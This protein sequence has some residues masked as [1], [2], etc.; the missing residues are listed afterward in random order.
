MRYPVRIVVRISEDAKE[1]LDEMAEAK[2][3]KPGTV[4]RRAIMKDVYIYKAKKNP[5]DEKAH[6]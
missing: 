2:R 1:T 5:K 3:T 6:E 4:A